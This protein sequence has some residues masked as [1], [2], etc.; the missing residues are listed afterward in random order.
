M[1]PPVYSKIVNKNKHSSTTYAINNRG[2]KI[3]VPNDE[4][5]K[6]TFSENS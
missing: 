4:N 6:R 5:N 2:L 3:T 1:K